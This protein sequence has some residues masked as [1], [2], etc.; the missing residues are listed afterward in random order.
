MFT[1]WVVTPVV[2]GTPQTPW[3]FFE[4]ADAQLRYQMIK[5]AIKDRT[6][7]TVALWE[8][9]VTPEGRETNAERSSAE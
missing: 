3:V 7:C 9:L 8:A 5:D 2:G 4:E 6:D 1:V